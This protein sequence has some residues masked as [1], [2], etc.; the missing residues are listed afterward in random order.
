MTKR[1]F[2][3][4]C[5]IVAG[6]NSLAQ[7]GFMPFSS[8]DTAA[9]A[10]LTQAIATDNLQH[11]VTAAYQPGADYTFELVYGSKDIQDGSDFSSILSAFQTWMDLPE[12]EISFQQTKGRSQLDLGNHNGRNEI[13]WVSA[14]RFGEQAWTNLLDFSPRDIAVTVTW[15]YPDTGRIA[16][17][18]IY[19]NDIH[20][21]WRT[22]T[23]GIADGGFLIEHIALHEIGHIYGLRDLYN[24]GQSGYQSWMGSGNEYL[25][26]YGYSQWWNSDTTLAPADIRAMALAHPAAMPEPATALLL[27]LG[28]VALRIHRP[29]SQKHG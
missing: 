24:P 13:T 16:E 12:S 21:D 1:T 17:R 4:C 15:Y 7:A 8:T 28:S 5:I 23:D 20:M 22:E 9:P 27:I 18:D 10:S 26:M 2:W 3:N 11:M 14:E 6:L 29:Y 25:T 19:F